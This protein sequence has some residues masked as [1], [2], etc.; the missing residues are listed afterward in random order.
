[1]VLVP[2]PSF[3][4]LRGVRVCPRSRFAHLPLFI[5][6]T[7]S[8]RKPRRKRTTRN[9]SARSSWR[10][11]SNP[12]CQKSRR[13][14]ICTGN[15]LQRRDGRCIAHL[16]TVCMCMSHRQMDEAIGAE[17]NGFE[18]VQVHATGL[19]KPNVLS[20]WFKIFAAHTVETGL[21]CVGK[22][23]GR[24]RRDVPGGAISQ[25]THRGTRCP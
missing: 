21:Q 20:A 17:F 11:S 19:A 7:K 12:R 9:Q 14:K 22:A 2:E 16:T 5:V 3:S 23:R 25:L 13:S 6:L 15:I 24:A 1:M 18:W 8:H 10:T 4:S